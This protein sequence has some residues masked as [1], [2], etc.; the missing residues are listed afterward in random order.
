MVEGSPAPGFLTHRVREYG[1]GGDSSE[2]GGGWLIDLLIKS[3]N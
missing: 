3:I 2:F 1:H